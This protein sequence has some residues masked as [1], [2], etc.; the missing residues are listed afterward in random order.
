MSATA[1]D[2]GD[3]VL[4]V[5]YSR[6]TKL[7][8][9]LLE[10]CRLDIQGGRAFLMGEWLRSDVDAWNNGLVVAIGW[11]CVSDYLV[12]ESEQEYRVRRK[13][14]RDTHDGQNAKRTKK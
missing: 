8:D 6:G 10:K 13:R 12:Y 1:I 7:L 2:F 14:Y 3:K 11:D 5:R 9:V 4:H